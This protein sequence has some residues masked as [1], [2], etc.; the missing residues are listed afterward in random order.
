MT[1]HAQ[2]IAIVASVLA[3]AL[4]LGALVHRSVDVAAGAADQERRIVTANLVVEAGT[5]A[6]SPPIALDG[7]AIWITQVSIRAG[8]A[9]D[10]T[11]R[12]VHRMRDDLEWVPGV[13]S[14][15]TGFINSDRVRAPFGALEF[16]NNGGDAVTVAVSAFL[17]RRDTF[18]DGR[19]VAS[20]SVVVQDPIT[21]P[22]GQFRFAPPVSLS[23]ATRFTS[24]LSFPGGHTFA[25]GTITTAYEA[26][27]Y[28]PQS[29][30]FVGT[31][32]ATDRNISDFFAGFFPTLRM[33]ITNGSAQSVD[34]IAA[35]Y[36]L[37]AD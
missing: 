2:R 24:Q 10:F 27:I 17:E 32:G 14:F 12:Q 31:A 19:R 26:K 11:W 22:P 8:L 4:V 34:V 7:F 20:T 23:G 18:A 33:K 28:D 37:T 25:Q 29:F 30:S 13:P 1:R 35:H 16:R 21:I 36:L 9:T 15:G 5:T 6:F 3:G